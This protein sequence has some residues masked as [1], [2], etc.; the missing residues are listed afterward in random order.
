[1]VKQ[2][3]SPSTCPQVAILGNSAESHSVTRHQ[4]G[5]QW[6]NLS[7]LQPPPPGFKQFSCLSLP[8]SWFLKFIQQFRVKS[9]T[10]SP[11][12]RLECS[13]VTSAHC[14]LRL[15]GSS[16]SPAS[17]S[18]VAGTTGVRHHVQLI[19]FCIFSRD[20]F[21]HLGQDDLHLLTSRSLA[22]VAQAGVQSQ[23]TATSASRVQAVL[24]PPPPKDRVSLL[25][26]LECSG[27][28]IAHG[29][30][31][32]LGSRGLESYSVAEARV[33]WRN[34]GSLQPP[35]P[36]FK[37][38]SPLSLLMETGFHHVGQADLELLI[39]GDP[40]IWA[41]QSAGITDVNEDQEQI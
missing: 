15:P 22:L 31:E 40:P 35:P 12:T 30:L 36:G 20:G 3:K 7:S 33:Q 11:G 19:F 38:F 29:S 18:Q 4:A 21:H 39:S 17:A 23:L 24:L 14:N 1:M 10:P 27:T 16:N 2:T 32:L 6:R 41:S 26:R 5:V 8:S 9:L 13:G 25:F 34:L 37:Q 28:I